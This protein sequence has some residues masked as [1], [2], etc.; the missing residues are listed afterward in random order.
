MDPYQII[1]EPV[2]T[3]KAF[4]ASGEKKYVFKVH[5]DATKVDVRSA[6]AKI[7]KVKVI[8][9]NTVN[10]K[11][12]TRMLGNKVGRTSSYKK[13]YV[14]ISKDQKIEELEV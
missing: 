13:A 2:V 5:K 3:E 8:D 10:V 1:L 7:F 11:G 14:T 6:V 12:K 9:V 4:G